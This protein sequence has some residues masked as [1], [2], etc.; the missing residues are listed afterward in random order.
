MNQSPPDPGD[1]GPGAEPEE[2]DPPL[3]EEGDEAAP[4]D[5]TAPGEPE[6]GSRK[7]RPL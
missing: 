2:D 7:Y 6:T 5:E 1:D 3:A 4:G